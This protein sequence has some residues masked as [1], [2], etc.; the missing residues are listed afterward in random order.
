M[1]NVFPVKSVL[2][3]AAPVTACG[4]LKEGILVAAYAEVAEKTRQRIVMSVIL[5]KK[6]QKMFF[7]DMAPDSVDKGCYISIP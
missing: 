3:M 7:M 2:F 6:L 5:P 1:S 4:R